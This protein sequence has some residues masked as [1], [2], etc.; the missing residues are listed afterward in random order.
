MC[1]GWKGAE[2]PSPAR[3]GLWE[4]FESEGNVAASG[5]LE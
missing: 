1:L 2:Q 3:Q 4:M 5:I